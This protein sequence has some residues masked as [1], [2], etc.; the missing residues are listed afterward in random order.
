MEYL[1]MKAR[2]PLLLKADEEKWKDT[3]YTNGA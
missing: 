1:L 3:I 2:M